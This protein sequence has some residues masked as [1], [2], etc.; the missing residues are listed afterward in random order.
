MNQADFRKA[1]NEQLKTFLE[2]PGGQQLLQVLGAMRPAYEFAQ[3]PHLMAE[4]RGAM[5]GYEL[6]LR[7]IL[8]LS[9]PYTVHQ[10]V[11]PTYGVPTV[12]RNA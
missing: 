1:Y 5:R 12:G 2:T 3:Q 6:C 11:E 4:N 7:N 9:M 8:G 10:E